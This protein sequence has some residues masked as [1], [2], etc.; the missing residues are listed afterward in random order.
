[1]TRTIMFITA[2]T[3]VSAKH[4][5]VAA[6]LAILIEIA[7][8]A[9]RRTAITAITIGSS[10]G[11]HSLR[12]SPAGAVWH[13]HEGPVEPAGKFTSSHPASVTVIT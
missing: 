5:G 10:Q 9:A 12:S 4:D 7:S 3:D 8:G 6:G 13:R 2:G 1:M 11:S